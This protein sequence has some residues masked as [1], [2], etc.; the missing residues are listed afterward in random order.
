MHCHYFSC[1]LVHLFKFISG[2][3]GKGSG[4]SNEGYS[5]GIYSFG[6]VSAR[7]FCL[8]QFSSSPEIFFLNFVFHFHLFDGVCLQDA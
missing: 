4:I 1:S 8:K 2:P 6:K 3:L 7:K 5:P